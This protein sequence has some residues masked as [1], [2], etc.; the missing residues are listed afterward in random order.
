[1]TKTTSRIHELPEVFRGSEARAARLITKRQLS[2]SKVHRFFQDAY[3][4]ADVPVTHEL[5]CRAAAL[6]MPKDAVLTGRSA[7]T[8]RGVE[9][10]QPY[11]PVEIVVPEGSRFGPIKGI[12][13][14][15]TAVKPK[16]SRAWQQIRI[17]KPARIALDLVLRLSPRTRNWSR[18]LR[19]SVPDLD[20]FL[21]SGLVSQ[22]HLRAMLARRRNRGIVLAREA[23][24][25]SDPRAES[26]PESDV[27]VLFA[28]NRYFLKPQHE[29]IHN[30]RCL[31]RLDLGDEELQVAV[32]YDGR[33]WHFSP[34]QIRHDR[35]RRK[36]LEEAGWIFVIVDAERLATDYEGIIAEYE[37][38]RAHQ[39]AR[40]G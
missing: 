31:A 17:A 8:V 40:F 9:L 24:N 28:L 7:A 25:L 18:R 15:R 19:T 2:G 4:R 5:R 29:V 23:L 20:A 22:K 12:H 30:G 38:A 13:I 3:A 35:R 27:R 32:E 14:R 36:R 1:M 26:R 34:E 33:E 6:I 21:R 37:K 10:A 39:A 16:E 11:D